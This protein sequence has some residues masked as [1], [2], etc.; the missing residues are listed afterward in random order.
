MKKNS[1]LFF[2]AACSII[3]LQSAWAQDIH[4][5][6]YEAAPLAVNPAFTGTFDGNVRASVLYRNQWA[7]VTIPYITYGA[8]F[9]MP[10]FTGRK[11]DYLAA[12]MQV[13][14]DQAG[15]GGLNNFSGLA[16]VAYH[17]FF[18]YDPYIKDQHGCDFAIGLQGGYVQK[19]IS[20]GDVFFKNTYPYPP[21]GNFLPG[22][23]VLLPVAYVNTESAFTINAGLCFSQ[24]V[25]TRFNYTIGFSGSNLN[26]PG[27]PFTQRQNEQLGMD[28]MY[29]GVFA[30]NWIVVNRLSLKPSVLYLSKETLTAVIAGNE[31]CYTLI[32]KPAR[33]N[34]PTSLFLGGWYRTGDI[35]TITAGIEFNAFRIGVGYDY[36]THSASQASMPDGTT[37]SN[38]GFEI[39]VRY[40]APSAH[41]RAI[42]CSRF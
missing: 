20:L 28:R 25:G 8:S 4:Y 18:G 27:D 42:P 1:R 13:F 12:G 7:S 41:K 29:T 22:I 3:F 37:N 23:G 5:V 32:K 14:K 15:D 11:G 2:T 33:N 26:Q 34:H 24:S 39:S 38:G 9:D 31:F 35:E 21:Y 10:V 40:V 36:D 6:Q 19:S 17:K 30:A 16:S